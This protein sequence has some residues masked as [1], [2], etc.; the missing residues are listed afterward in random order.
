MYSQVQTVT[1][2]AFTGIASTLTDFFTTGKSN[3]SDFLFHFPQ[4]IAQMLTNWL[5]LMGMKSAFGGTIIGAFFG[6]QVVV[7]GPRF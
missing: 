5:W 3:Y 4:G 7:F 2:N 6:F 1:S